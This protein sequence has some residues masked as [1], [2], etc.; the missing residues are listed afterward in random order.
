M[1][2]ALFVAAYG[3]SA[4]LLAGCFPT[5]AVVSPGVSGNVRLNGVAL[6]G[7]EV[8]IQ[9]RLRATG[10]AATSRK[11][12]TDASGVFSIPSRRSLKWV[13]PGDRLVSWGVCIRSNSQWFDGY[14]EHPFGFPRAKVR[15][16]CD[17]GAPATLESSDFATIGVCREDEA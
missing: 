2:R 14:G 13:V 3:L 4:V 5:V 7:A 1:K 16:A 11:A 17:L 8:Y 12:T 15:L 10:C 9:D 6:E